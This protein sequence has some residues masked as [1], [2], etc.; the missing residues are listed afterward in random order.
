MFGCWH[1]NLSRPFT[2]SGWTYE[3]CLNCENKLAHDGAEIA[4][5][6]SRRKSPD[7]SDV[8]FADKLLSAMSYQRGGTWRNQTATPRQSDQR[9]VNAR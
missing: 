5:L 9:R 7:R 8:D 6:F 1:R 2:R 3:V 4:C